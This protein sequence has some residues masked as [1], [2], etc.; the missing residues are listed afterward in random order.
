MNLHDIVEIDR[1][2][3]LAAKRRQF[4]L[5]DNIVY[6]DGN[7]LGALPI[8]A[9]NRSLEVMNQQWGRDLISSWNS[10][11]WID[12]PTA[13]GEKIAP[14]LGAASGQVICCDSTS[15]NL[16]KLLCTALGMQKNRKVV[17]SQT[18]NFPADLYRAQG[19]SH[20]GVADSC[21]LELCE[22]SEIEER[23]Y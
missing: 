12:L 23:L 14:L 1:V 3:P 21:E 20:L 11:G 7:S 10:H 6:L 2:D 15:V 13:V 5:A 16:F 18:D 8:A 19:L 4:V 22:D 17:I 9:Q